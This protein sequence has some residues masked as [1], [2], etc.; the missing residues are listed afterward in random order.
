MEPYKVGRKKENNLEMKKTL[1]I[2]LLFFTAISF[3]QQRIIKVTPTGGIVDST[4]EP[5]ITPT[6]I[7]NGYWN[8]FKHFVTFN[9]DSIPNAVS[10]A[11]TQ[12]LTNKTLTSP[13]LNSPLL[14]TSSTAGYIWTA[15]NT[16]GAGSWQVNSG[17][18]SPVTSVTG[19][20]GRI[21]STG[22]TT[23]VIDIGSDVGTLSGNQTYLGRKI[24]SVGTTFNDTV[25]LSKLNS[26]DNIFRLP[27]QANQTF[28]IDTSVAA[29]QGRGLTF[30][31]GASG[32][33]T[34]IAGGAVTLASGQGTGTGLSRVLVSV[35]AALASG[36]TQQSVLTPKL[37]IQSAGV[38]VGNITPTTALEVNG[39][40]TFSGTTGAFSAGI[41]RAYL[42]AT[43]GF[44]MTAG[45][46]SSHDLSIVSAAGQYVFTNIHS[47]NNALL[48]PSGN[49]GIGA[50]T[51]PTSKVQITGSFSLI[52]TSTATSLTLTASHNVVLVTATGQTI[53]LP[54]AVGANGRIYTIKLTASG[55]GTVA[56][57]SSQ[58][59]DGSTTYSLSAQNKYVT[60]I[61]ENSQWFIIGNN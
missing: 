23:P 37:T 17:G 59:I 36:S 54:T 61:S 39:A 7:A 5:I 48:T 8:R 24:Y 22:G 42:D 18:G 45:T 56:T 43:S 29:T 51:T 58:T 49:V 12:T 47:T 30:Q 28:R 19:T 34:D 60:V 11:G 26:S 27:A 38:G 44:A 16:S 35:Y 1:T 33:G 32:A 46:G 4:K 14:N 57:T 3:G 2:L 52:P 31:S 21:T 55:T 13:Q 50:S 9:P 20:S 25:Y 53:T 6:N 40:V 10:L 41:A 15:T